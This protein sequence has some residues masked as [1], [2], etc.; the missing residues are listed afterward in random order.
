LEGEDE[1]DKN[2]KKYKVKLTNFTTYIDGVEQNYQ[3]QEDKFK[4]D[5]LKNSLNLI[6]SLFSSMNSEDYIFN[7]FS[8]L[9]SKIKRNHNQKLSYVFALDR[10]NEIIKQEIMSL[11]FKKFV[12]YEPEDGIF[13]NYN[14]FTF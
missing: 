8:F 6:K 13:L 4:V 1:I 14:I 11:L 5:T 3:E 10:N 12:F 2:E 7:F 9:Y